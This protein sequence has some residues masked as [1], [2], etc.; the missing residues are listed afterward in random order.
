[1]R[2]ADLRLRPGV[3]DAVRRLQAAGYLLFLITN[4]P[5]YAKGKTG[6]ENLLAVQAHFAALMETAGVVFQAFYYSFSHPASRRAGFSGPCPDR[7]PEPFFI[8]KAARE[9]RLDLKASWMVGDRE[10]DIACGQQ[11]GLR[12]LRIRNPRTPAH[13]G[14]LEP[15]CLVEDLPEAATI[16]LSSAGHLCHSAASAG[17]ALR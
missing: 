2:A 14:E 6:L 11:A 10:S 8:L 4:Q 16:L 1:L 5:S 17:S 9:H 13:S 15:T 7:K 12:T 3:T